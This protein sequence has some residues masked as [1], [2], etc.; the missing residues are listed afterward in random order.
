ME[1]SAELLW[2][3][4][5]SFCG[6]DRTYRFYKTGSVCAQP[7]FPREYS[8]NKGHAGGLGTL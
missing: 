2:S 4:R 6:A 5:G 7:L 3:F 8:V 1:L